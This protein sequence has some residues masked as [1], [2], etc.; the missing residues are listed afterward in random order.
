MYENLRIAS[1][2]QNRPNHV[3]VGSNPPEALTL[4]Q[5]AVRASAPGTPYLQRASSAV[6]FGAHFESSF[7]LQFAV[8][9][10]SNEFSNES[11]SSAFAFSFIDMLVAVTVATMEVLATISI[12]SLRCIDN[13][14]PDS[15]GLLPLAVA[16]YAELFP[17]SVAKRAMQQT[18]AVVLLIIIIFQ[19]VRN[20]ELTQVKVKSGVL[21]G[22]ICE[23]RRMQDAFVPGASASACSVERA[24]AACRAAC[25]RRAPCA[26]DAERRRGSQ[27]PRGGMWGLG[28]SS[29][30]V[31][32][33][34]VLLLYLSSPGFER[35]INLYKHTEDRSTYPSFLVVKE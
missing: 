6:S 34:Y 5:A 9:F 8:S 7:G 22:G 33:K 26:V 18:L 19:T 2:K 1:R 4:L 31:T 10:S 15:P 28:K 30:A 14:V 32:Q 23:F 24:G 29:D 35:R 27:M 21:C 17:A 25:M 16:E 12:I 3:L 13:A 20:G 11:I